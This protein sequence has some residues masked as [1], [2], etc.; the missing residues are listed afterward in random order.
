[1]IIIALVLSERGAKNA[2][3]GCVFGASFR[4]HQCYDYHVKER[5]FGLPRNIFFLGLTSFF[6][7]FSSEMIF[8]VFPAFFTSVLK[9]GAGSLGLVD[10][11]A[12]AASNLFKIYS[13][14]LSDRIQKRKFLVVSGYTLSV[15]IRPFYLLTSTIG[16][17][18][19]L[20]FFG[21]GGVG[22]GGG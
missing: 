21:L 5:I 1:M 19:G 4:K 12:E 13:G 9:A 18:V 2:P 10:G 20:G 14:N 22:R 16:G 11:V 3:T 17:G 6:N 8:S 7:D 15:L